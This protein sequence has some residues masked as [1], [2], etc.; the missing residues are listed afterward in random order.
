M[1]ASPHPAARQWADVPALLHHDTRY[2]REPEPLSARIVG[3]LFTLA[4]AGITSAIFSRRV[5]AVRSW[6][7]L[8]YIRWLVLLQCMGSFAYTIFQSIIQYAFNPDNDPVVCDASALVCIMLYA[9]M[10]GLLYLFL[11][12]RL[13][14][15]R[16]TLKS[17]KQSKLFLF[18]T[19]GIC[20]KITILGAIFIYMRLHY[21]KGDVCIIGA[22]KVLMI[23][24]VSFDAAVNIYL[25][26]FFLFFLSKSFKL[27][28]FRSSV[29]ASRGIHSLSSIERPQPLAKKINKLTNRTAIGLVVTLGA[30]MINLATMTIMDGEVLWL[31]FLTCKAD[32][33]LCVV[34]LNYM[35]MG[36]D[37][38]DTRASAT[39]E[40]FDQPSSAQ[41]SNKVASSNGTGNIV[42]TDRSLADI[43]DV[44]SSAPADLVGVP[45]TLKLQPPAQTYA[46]TDSC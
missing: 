31:C 23:C 27:H 34:I 24:V 43:D 41:A 37:D 12:D 46:K 29:M 8:P 38:R 5:A 26:G 44:I 33:L 22:Q 19:I 39:T 35:L 1:M 2:Y 17:R 4:T 28:P 36:G 40:R 10:K 9:I 15:V 32:N 45:R 30:T 3:I 16:S 20:I 7:R 18:H 21:I 13:H 6:K 14:V 42:R 25:T 11:A